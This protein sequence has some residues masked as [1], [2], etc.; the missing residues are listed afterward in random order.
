MPPVEAISIGISILQALAYAHEQGV[1]HR[2]IKPE[3]I[4]ITPSGQVKVADFSLARGKDD[5]RLTQNGAITGTVAYLAPESLR[6][7]DSGPLADL[8]SL[9]AV[10]YELLTGRLPFE[11]E[12]LAMILSKILYGAIEPLRTFSSEISVALEQFLLR[13]LATQPEMRFPSAEEALGELER[14]QRTEYG[15]MPTRANEPGGPDKAFVL[16]GTSGDLAATVEAE[17]RQLAGEIQTSIIEPLNLLLAQANTFEQT[18][19][20]QP[21]TRMAISVLSSLARQVL[22]RAHDL[23]ANLHPVILETLGLAPAFEALA[24]QYERSYN[25]HLVLNLAPLPQRPPPPLELELFRLVQEVLEALRSQRI[26][27]AILELKPGENLLMLDISFPATA[28]L[29]EQALAAIR[30]RLEPLGGELGLG[31]SAQ[32]QTHLSMRIPFRRD[33]S[34]TKREQQVLEGLVQGLSNKQIA[35]QLTVSP[36]TVNYHLDNI[37]SKLGVRT[38]TEAAVIASHQGLGQRPAREADRA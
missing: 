36:R 33:I 18:L 10:L 35:A 6:G 12:S 34:F 20:P 8:Y 31:R 16:V 3:N 19:P 17:R 15:G 2:D 5:R 24:N 25:L 38:R 28:F 22:Q 30:Q 27:Q 29:S 21:A 9:G 37:F 14:I 32:G 13:L 11:G 26:T 7:V 4:L 23:E 1:V